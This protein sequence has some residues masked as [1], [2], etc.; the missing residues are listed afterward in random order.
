MLIN[1]TRLRTRRLFDKAQAI[2]VTNKTCWHA[3][4]FVSV[5]MIIA[6]MLLFFFN[7]LQYFKMFPNCS[8]NLR[9]FLD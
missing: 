8:L 7:L 3:R 4:D 6:I 1:A 5:N 2:L 9:K